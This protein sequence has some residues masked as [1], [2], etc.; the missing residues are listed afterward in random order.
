MTHDTEKT[1][2][3]RLPGSEKNE[4]MFISFDRIH[5]RGRQ[6]DAQRDRQTPH[7]GISRACIASRGKKISQTCNLVYSISCFDDNDLVLTMTMS[8]KNNKT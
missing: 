7:D 8:S 4:D 5:K 2:M 1:R 6:T 3:V